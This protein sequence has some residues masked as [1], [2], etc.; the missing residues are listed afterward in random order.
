MYRYKIDK[1]L[2]PVRS[3][4][5]SQG[6]SGAPQCYAGGQG[7]LADEPDRRLL[8]GA[9]LDC[10]ALEQEYKISGGSAPPLP[11]TAFV[12]FFLTEPVEQGP[13][14]AIWVE[15]VDVLEPG[16]PGSRNIVRDIVQLY[17]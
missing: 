14:Q 13:D 6:E 12:R 9:V 5:N 8:H 2:V 4:P 10:M 16:I 17:R 11:V 3:G 15:L 1:N 7:T